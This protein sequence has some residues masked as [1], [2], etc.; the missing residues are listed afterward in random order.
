M[1]DII[2]DSSMDWYN[3]IGIETIV[4]Y[5]PYILFKTVGKENLINV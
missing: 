3:G 4:G 5:Y 1:K 2:Q